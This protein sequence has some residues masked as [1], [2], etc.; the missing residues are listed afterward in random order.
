MC[1]M[2]LFKADMHCHSNFSDGV[3][4]PFELIALCHELGLQGLSI[5]D[6]DSIAAYRD[7]N[8]FLWAE[9][10]CVRLCPGVEISSISRG[11]NIHVL[12]YAFPLPNP[13]LQELC[14][15]YEKNRRNRNVA[16]LSRLEKIGFYM[17][18]EELTAAFPL[19]VIGR[20]HIAKLLVKKGY[21]DT[22]QKAFR[23]FLGE[24]GSC[25]VP[26]QSP[27]TGEVIE[28]IHAAG[29]KAF[30][31]HPHLI[32]HKS[33]LR[34]L[35]T[36][37]FDGIECYY[38]RFPNE[39]VQYWKRIATQRNMLISGGSDYHGLNVE[40]NLLGS[41]WVNEEDFSRIIS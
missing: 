4:T 21:I 5:T 31:A 32:K 2:N 6:H 20:P 1:P 38:A 24:T 37:P 39:Q 10:H 36:L 17:N 34:Y 41:S 25:Y 23:Q 35:L 7:A 8:L 28:V 30:L 19:A 29:A 13:I 15:Q 33:I 12:A 9:K 27:S 40:Y 22:V 14:A 26:L 16:I 11:K 3:S 18:I